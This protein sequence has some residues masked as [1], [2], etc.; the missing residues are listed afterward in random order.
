MGWV[1]PEVRLP[2]VMWLVDDIGSPEVRWTKVIRVLPNSPNPTLWGRVRTG[3]AVGTDGIVL[4]SDLLGERS[5][6]T[7][8]VVMNI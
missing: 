6:C 3:G 5:E 7:P 1:S 8:K 2:E 4:F